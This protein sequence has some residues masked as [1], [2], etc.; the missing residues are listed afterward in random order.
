LSKDNICTSVED[1]VRK[2]YHEIHRRKILHGDIRAANILISTSKSIYI[3]DFESARPAAESN[4]EDEMA[5]VEKLFEKI[6]KAQE[7]ELVLR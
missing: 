5:E 6:R 1:K 3:I 2:A 7:Q 4:L